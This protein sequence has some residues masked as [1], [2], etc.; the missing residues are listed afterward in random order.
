MKK[1][2]LFPFKKKT[3]KEGYLRWPTRAKCTATTCRCKYRNEAK[4]E[5]EPLEEAEAE[6]D[7]PH[8][9]AGGAV[10]A[11]TPQDWWTICNP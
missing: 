5:V 3:S 2:L 4:A 1:I 11:D 9:A 10:G 7:A 8:E 6:A